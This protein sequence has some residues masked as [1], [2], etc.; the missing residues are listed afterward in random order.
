MAASVIQ[1]VTRAS[2]WVSIDVLHS[3]VFGRFKKYKQAGSHS[4]SFR[5]SNGRTDDA[6]EA[7]ISATRGAKMLE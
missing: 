3:L 5:L 2:W 1:K 7:H 6:G 4:N